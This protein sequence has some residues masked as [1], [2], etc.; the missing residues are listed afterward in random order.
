MKKT[1]MFLHEDSDTRLSIKTI[2]EKEGYE[3]IEVLNF[4]DFLK[5]INL[6]KIDL[7]LI[8]GSIPKE[9]IFKNIKDKSM[10]FAY[11][12]SGDIDL[13]D[14]NLYENIVGSV[15]KPFDKNYFLKRINNLLK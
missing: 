7:L 11:F 1:I 6:K 13:K 14:L 2:L 3:V 4:N 12:V 9:R 5:K 15:D 8:S 10:K